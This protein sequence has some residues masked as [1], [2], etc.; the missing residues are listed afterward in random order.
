[1]LENRIEPMANPLRIGLARKQGG[2][3][4]NLPI[5]C[6]ADRAK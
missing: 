2:M 5:E 3:D 4:M 6:P 1:M